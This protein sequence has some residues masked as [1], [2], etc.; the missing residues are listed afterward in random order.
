MEVGTGASAHS[1]PSVLVCRGDRSA[2]GVRGGCWRGMPV[3]K[4]VASEVPPFH[5]C[6]LTGEDRPPGGRRRNGLA[7]P[8]S[9]RQLVAVSIFFI[10]GLLFAAVVLPLMEGT[11]RIIFA[12][13][14]W[15]C[16]ASLGAFAMAVMKAD[17]VDPAVLS[18]GTYP[19]LSDDLSLA[20]TC[21]ECQAD[22]AFGSRH[23]WECDK[24]VANFDHH[25]LWLNTCV[26]SVNYGRFFATILSLLGM[27]TVLVSAAALLGAR[28]FLEGRWREDALSVC[29]IGAVALAHFMLWCLTTFLVFFHFLLCYKG[30]TT[31]EYLTGKKARP[32]RP[33]TETGGSPISSS[34]GGDGGAFG[35]SGFGS[36]A[37]HRGVV[38][39]GFVGGHDCESL[40]A[41]SYLGSKA[42]PFPRLTLPVRSTASAAVIAAASPGN[43]SPD[44]PSHAASAGKLRLQLRSGVATGN[45]PAA[46][47]ACSSTA[48]V[49]SNSKAAAG[50]SAAVV[51]REG[52]AAE[53]SDE[54]ENDCIEWPTDTFG[55]APAGSAS[56]RS[57]QEVQPFLGR[58]SAL[59]ESAPPGHSSGV[60]DNAGENAPHPQEG[61]CPG[62]AG[63]AM[64]AFQS[65][66]QVERE[67]DN[68]TGAASREELHDVCQQQH[69]HQ[70]KPSESTPL[71]D[72]D[73]AG[74]RHDDGELVGEREA[75]H[76]GTF[77]LRAH[78]EPL[79]LDCTEVPVPQEAEAQE[80]SV[81][82]ETQDSATE[83]V[84]LSPA[85]E[86]AR[87]GLEAA[88]P[89]ADDR[90]GDAEDGAVCASGTA[91]QACSGQLP[92]VGVSSEEVASP[93]PA[94]LPAGASA[95]DAVASADKG[96]GM[97][98]AES[99]LPS[100]EASSEESSAVADASPCNP[101]KAI[102]LEDP[103]VRASKHHDTIQTAELEKIL[104]SFAIRSDEEEA[105]RLGGDAH[106]ELDQ[107]TLGAPAER[108]PAAELAEPSQLQPHG[109]DYSAAGEAVLVAASSAACPLEEHT[110]PLHRQAALTTGTMERSCTNAGAE[111]SVAPGLAAP[112]QLQLTEP[113]QASATVEPVAAAAAETAQCSSGSQELSEQA[114]RRPSNL[115]PGSRQLQQRRS[116]SRSAPRRN[117]KQGP[118]AVHA[119]ERVS[120]SPA[121]AAE[122]G[123]ATDAQQ[124]N[125]AGSAVTEGPVAAAAAAAVAGRAYPGASG[126]ATAGRHTPPALVPSGRLASAEA[127]VLLGS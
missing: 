41:W 73:L 74:A 96:D 82:E 63:E 105:K 114:G 61:N 28:S 25:C 45:A 88:G 23:C 43:S 55:E 13:A 20:L 91:K 44:A 107:A 87:V 29:V 10:D 58:A 126:V 116:R 80:S 120:R 60:E 16:W 49:A 5:N 119:M 34:L 36:G 26:G 40:E 118:D 70:Q 65:W 53:D 62:D 35:S 115:S 92:E 67:A 51:R 9:V 52:P 109:D 93:D 97:V 112:T 46:S 83:A 108:A 42:D 37:A 32:A 123:Q 57:E 127:A 104:R 75:H 124:C 17:P 84:L 1:A 94:V 111:A 22:V 31:Y 89:E 48:G 122:R 50:E 18:S 68:T 15:P 100:T 102:D 39:A 54:A 125:A 8:P 79:Q 101:C 106:L 66:H 86:L 47:S 81:E 3:A 30:I 121:P 64:N 24:C 99:M 78:V 33:R 117:S 11:E 38:G 85:G 113:E 6:S 14:F 69:H 77:E 95:V 59:Q 4:S 98:V 72:Q 19:E 110:E 71:N 21:S 7:W 2:L 90:T 56:W 27:L 12:S 103:S 76:E